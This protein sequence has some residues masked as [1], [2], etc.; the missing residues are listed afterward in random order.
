MSRSRP[1]RLRDFVFL[2]DIIGFCVPKRGHWHDPGLK[3]RIAFHV[4][5]ADY[6][7]R[8][9]GD[10]ATLIAAD[11]ELIEQSGGNANSIGFKI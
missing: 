10:I 9:L 8:E 2:Y 1:F 7:V 5:F 4:P 11:I 6:N 3:S